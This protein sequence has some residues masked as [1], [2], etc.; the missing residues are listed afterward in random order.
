M[1]DH[2]LS[3]AACCNESGSKVRPDRPDLHG[4]SGPMHR[5]RVA[6]LG[7]V[8]GQGSLRRVEARSAGSE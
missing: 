1:F 3:Q 4:S 5:S 2:D 8:G 6:L 7:P